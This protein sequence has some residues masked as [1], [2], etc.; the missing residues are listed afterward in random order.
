MLLAVAGVL[1]WELQARGELVSGGLFGQ[2]DVNEALLIAPVLFLMT[3]GMLFFRVFPMFIRYIGGESLALVHSAAAVTLAVLTTGVAVSDLQAGDRTAWI[4][5]ALVLGGFGA[6]YWLTARVN[7]WRGKSLFTII[8]AGIVSAYLSGS[9]PHP[10]MP[11][12]VFA[13]SIAWPFSFRRRSYSTC[14]R[15]SHAGRRCGSH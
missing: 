8:Q 3:I 14:W 12:A 13:G 2:Q 9:P 5:D 7:G 10:D 6:V 1:F 15:S 4:S 11:A